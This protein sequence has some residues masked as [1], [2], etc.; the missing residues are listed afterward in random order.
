MVIN[1]SGFLLWFY[2]SERGF[3]AS[4]VTKTPLKLEGDAADGSF[5]NKHGRHVVGHVD[6]YSA[7]RQQIGEGKLLVKKIASVVR[8]ASS[9]PGLEARGTEVVTS[10]LLGA[11]SCALSSGF[12]SF[13]TVFHA[14]HLPTL[15]T[16]LPFT[17]SQACL[18]RLLFSL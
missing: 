4:P 2:F 13:S 11:R 5:A 9:C 15:Q 17:P 14:L 7:L 8:S 12:S 1:D 3:D 16:H 6:D 10:Q 18:L